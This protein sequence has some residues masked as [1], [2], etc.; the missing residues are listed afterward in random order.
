MEAGNAGVQVRI[1]IR[2]SCV[3]APDQPGVSRNIRM[4]SI[5]DRFL[6][7]SRVFIFCNGGKDLHYISSA[8]WMDRNFD[9]R[10]EVAVPILDKQLQKE[11]R[12]MLEIQW[13]DNTKARLIS[14]SDPNQYRR[15]EQSAKV[16]SQV[17]IH[18]YLKHKTTETN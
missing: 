15:N 14:Y 3:I 1:I 8:D 13:N 18:K 7:H 4:I 9:H 16:R 11:L 17:E 5:I 6:E 12:K 10:I 2:G